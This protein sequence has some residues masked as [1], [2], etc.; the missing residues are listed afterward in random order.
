LDVERVDRQ[1][2]LAELLVRAGV[3]REDRHAL[4]PVD[5]RSLLGHQVHAVEHRVDEQHVVMLVGRHRLLEV[6]S[7]LQLDGHPV[8]RAV[9]VVDDRHERLD[10]LE[11]LGV[12]GHVGPRGHHL[13]HERHPLAELGVFLEK[14]VE[15]REAAQHVLA[16]VGPVD[17]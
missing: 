9:T 2:V 16:Q 1:R 14:Q 17:A 4:A 12:L 11:V 7:Q 3:L 15:G 5:D 13:R 6:V 10:P 8:G